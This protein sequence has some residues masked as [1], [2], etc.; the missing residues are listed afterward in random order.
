MSN[1]RTAGQSLG[2]LLGLALGVSATFPAAAAPKSHPGV[3][4]TR[5][6]HHRT[7]VVDGVQIFYRE[8]GPTDGPAVVLLHGFP[9]SSRMYR[10]L[11]P[12]L[13]DRYHV[14]AP[15]YPGFGS[16]AVPDRTAFAYTFAHYAEL[17][18]GLLTRLGV[19]R[20][21][22]Y[23]QDYG[24]PVGYRL[25]LRHP[26]R[27]TALV[28]QNGNAYE[29]GLRDFWKP[30]RELW[31]NPSPE[32][33]HALRAALT[34]EA[35]KGQYLGGV[36]DPSRIDPDSWILDQALLQRPGVDEIM[37]DLFLDYGTNVALYPKFQEFFRT[38]RPPTLIVWGKNDVIFP[39]EGATP[40]QRDNA[41]VELHL[42]DTGHF[43]LEDKLDE[44][45]TLMRDF[46][47]RK[48]QPHR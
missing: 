10:N 14:I 39:A 18:D 37:L 28:V 21:A 41:S 31:A 8:A 6:T 42:L 7:A 23:V 25:A 4:E 43:A 19:D 2:A 27:V 33:R 44:I 26:E 17:V 45:A 5:V 46:L 40:Y 15:D 11:I 13:A 38:R 32:H 20:Y 16:S 36:K 48:L 35:T 29:E 9:T 34:L 24:A 1:R 47:D 30:L 22:L 3:S 12:R